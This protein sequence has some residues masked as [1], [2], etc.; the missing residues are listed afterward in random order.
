[1]KI[2][3]QIKN[4]IFN[5][6][7]YNN[8]VLNESFKSSLKY[9]AKLSLLVA[10]FGII[11]F[12]FFI[13]K[14]TKEIKKEVSSFSSNYPEDLVVSVKNGEATINRTEP[15][16]VK[17]PASFIESEDYKSLKIDNILTINTAEPF[18]IEKFREYSTISLLTKKELIVMQTERGDVNI[19]PLSNLGDVEINKTLVLE[20]E[21]LI[22]KI[23]PW[24]MAFMLPIGY[25]LIFIGLFMGT[26]I[27]NFFYAVIVWALL[28]IKGIH[29]SYIKSYQV[30]IHA[31]TILLIFGMFSRF[32]GPLDNALTRALI[33]AFII[34]LNFDN[35]SNLIK[36]KEAEEVENT[37]VPE[38]KN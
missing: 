14:I 35:K 27:I 21:I 33:L 29:L 4:S 18:N 32:L 1:M 8:V 20:K 22:N 2:Y 7:Y 31:V 10:L 38:E 23:L 3:T 37:E 34:Y 12:S 13:P 15:F 19:L 16:V 30:S 17:M 9:L 6:D 25:M 24:V 28:K 11:I 26:I 5:K 36:T